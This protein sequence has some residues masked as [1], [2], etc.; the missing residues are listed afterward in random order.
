MRN[1]SSDKEVFEKINLLHDSLK[2]ND[3]FGEIDFYPSRVLMQ[4]LQGS[5]FSRFASMRESVKE[6]SKID[7]SVIIL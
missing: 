4:D 7:A 5:S 1:N 6:S 2:G 3:V